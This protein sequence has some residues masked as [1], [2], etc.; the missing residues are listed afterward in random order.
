MPQN[1]RE[2]RHHQAEQILKNLSGNGHQKG[3]EL[4]CEEK[5]KFWPGRQPLGG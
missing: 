4:T 5:E 3:Q 2:R 1:S